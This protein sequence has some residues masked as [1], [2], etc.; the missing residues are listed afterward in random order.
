MHFEHHLEHNH[1]I[2]L[3]ISSFIYFYIYIYIFIN[4]LL[5]FEMDI[6][7]GF[8]TMLDTSNYYSSTSGHLSDR[9]HFTLKTSLSLHNFGRR[10]YGCC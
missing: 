8:L 7:V 1:C 5:P 6:G 3:E 10:F 2:P 4:F 9:E